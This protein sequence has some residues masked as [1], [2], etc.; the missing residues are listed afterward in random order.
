M[1]LS[2]NYLNKFKVTEI[3]YSL[4]TKTLQSRHILNRRTKQ[5]KNENGGGIHK[6]ETS[7][8]TFIRSAHLWLC[9]KWL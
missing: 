1:F 5:K 3:I 8:Y 9:D 7:R 4:V 2:I 6:N